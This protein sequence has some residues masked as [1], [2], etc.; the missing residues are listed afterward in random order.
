MMMSSLLARLIE[1]VMFDLLR[2]LT[3]VV[4]DLLSQR[5]GTL[6]A[7]Q[8]PFHLSCSLASLRLAQPMF[9]TFR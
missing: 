3:S 1:L 9:S 4:V 8:H 7:K 6:I 2:L 5:L